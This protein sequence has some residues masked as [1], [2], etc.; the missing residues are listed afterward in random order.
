M[1]CLSCPDHWIDCSGRKCSER[2]RTE[3]A[4][5]RPSSEA[6]GYQSGQCVPELRWLPSEYSWNEGDAWKAMSGDRTSRSMVRLEIGFWVTFRVQV[7]KRGQLPLSLP[8]WLLSRPF[9]HHPAHSLVANPDATEDQ[10]RSTP[11]SKK[12]G[13]METRW[14]CWFKKKVNRSLSFQKPRLVA[15]Q[16]SSGLPFSRLHLDL[17]HGL[18]HAVTSSRA[19]AFHIP[20]N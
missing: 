15:V 12:P 10:H 18:S 16:L 8:A 7:W 11:L 2:A 19:P 6:A 3:S 14:T 1:L 17:S 20:D 9:W 13:V 5:P 4:R